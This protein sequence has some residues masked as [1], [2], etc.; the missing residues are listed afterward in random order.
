MAEKERRI[1]RQMR[2][3]ELSA[4]DTPAQEGAKFVLAKRDDTKDGGDMYL[5][6]GCGAKAAKPGNCKKCDKP[7][8]QMTDEDTTKRDFTHDE[9]QHLASTG[10]A[11]PDGSFPIENKEDL[12]NAIHAWGR[13]NPDKRGAVARHIARRA[14]ALGLTDML[15][16]EGELAQAAGSSKRWA[17]DFYATLGDDMTEAEKLAKAEKDLADVTAEKDL[18]VKVAAMSDAEK[19]HYTALKDLDVEG[20]KKFLDMD[21]AARA[22][23]IEKAK[24]SDPVI[25]TDSEGHQYHKSEAKAAALAKRADDTAKENK[26]LKEAAASGEFEKRAAEYPHLKGEVAEKVALLKAVETITDAEMK[27]KVIEMLKANDAGLAAAMKEL[28]TKMGATVTGPEATLNKM[29]ED[30][31]KTDNITFAKAYDIVAQTPEGKKLYEEML[32][33]KK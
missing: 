1:I 27:G 30:K 28:G 5:C 25:Y 14:K 23:E 16:T 18:L 24:N 6:A 2:I 26:A 29:A 3:M 9:R 20:A 4:V 7:M 19:A 10:A 32:T 11:M 22:A 12:A 21:G 15:P 13:A 33:A 17:D 8:K 31:A